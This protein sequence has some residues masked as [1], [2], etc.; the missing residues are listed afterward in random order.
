AAATPKLAG[1]LVAAPAPSSHLTK[2]IQKALTL[3]VDS[4]STREALKCL[5]GFF[6]E[7]TV[8]SRR[9]LRSSIEGQNLLLHQ[10]LSG[11]CSRSRWR[12]WTSSC[13]PWTQLAKPPRRGAAAREQGG[14]P[15]HPPEGHGVA[16][17][18]EGH[19]GQAGRAREV[20]GPLPPL[21][22]GHAARALGGQAS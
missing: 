17:G 8:H 4:Q 11:R 6:G 13:P 15:G 20:S 7:N 18:V 22:G 19:R 12:I 14:D 21:G 2:K 1:S 16:Q 10:E 9:N 3:R 5:S